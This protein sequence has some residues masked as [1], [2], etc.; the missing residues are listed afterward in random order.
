[1]TSTGEKFLVT[2]AAGCIGAWAIRLLLD[3]G[4]EVIASDLSEDLR[5]LELIS[6]AKGADVAFRQLDV[7]STEAV[8][9][10]IA[11]E[12]ITH[13]VHLAGLQVPFCA[14]NPP[15]GAAVNVLGTV[16]I[17]E[18]VRY[19]GRRV[20][21]AYASSAAVFGASSSFTSGVIRDDSPLAPE[22]F[23]GVYKEANEGTARV[24]SMSHGIGSVGLRPFIVY[25]PGRDQGMT[26]DATKAI[27]AATAGTPFHIKFGGNVLLTYA[28]DCA[29]AFIESARAATGSG[30]AVCLNVPG[31]RVGVA[32]LVDLLEE[33]LP[34][35]RGLLTWEQKPILA[36]ALLAEPALGEVIG[37]VRNKEL[38]DGVLETIAVF[39]E[40][41]A[42][43]KISAPES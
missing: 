28:P 43:G 2:G 9:S 29:S 36:P 4:V 42:A 35:S 1:M 10:L 11:D 39:R 31:R 41:L 40:A 18:G 24:Y 16:N 8:K 15:L 33:L 30:D 34:G 38:R 19:A 23:Y 21:L 37:G 20:G 26:S 5:R 6:G 14:A 22:S 27:L 32:A 17:F 3:E 12:G 25:G 13:V 7:T